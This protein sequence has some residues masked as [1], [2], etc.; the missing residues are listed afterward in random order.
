MYNI[1]WGKMLSSPFFLT[2]HYMELSGELHSLASLCLG[3]S[4]LNALDW[5]LRPPNPPGP[6]D[7]E[8]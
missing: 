6:C 8:K 7:V 5:R 1:I 3:K 4:P 2:R